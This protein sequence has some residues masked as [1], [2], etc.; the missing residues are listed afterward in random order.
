MKLGEW[1]NADQGVERCLI[2]LGKDIMAIKVRFQAGAVGAMH[3]HPHEQLTIVASGTFRFSVD[4]VAR[5]VKSGDT[6]YIPSNVPHGTQALE[7]GELIDVFTPL[8]LDLLEPELAL[9]GG[10]A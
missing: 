6:L 5:L 7:S 1:E 3:H 2:E 9:V 4:G 8:R 10:R